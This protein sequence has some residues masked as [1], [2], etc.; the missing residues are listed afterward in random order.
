[1]KTFSI[2]MVFILALSA[3]ADPITLKGVAGEWEPYS[4]NFVATLGKMKVSR[5]SI[6][7][8]KL[9]SSSIVEVVSHESSVLVLKLD[10]APKERGCGKFVRLGPINDTDINVAFYSSK[11]EFKKSSSPNDS[12]GYSMGCSWGRFTRS[13]SQGTP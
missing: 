7:W 1:M 8:E 9:G 4:R 6:S 3:K 2:L 13:K 5:E 10:K 11:S 12:D